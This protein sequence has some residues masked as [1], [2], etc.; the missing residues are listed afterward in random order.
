[1]IQARHLE[2]VQGASGSAT[3]WIGAAE[4]DATKPNVNNRAGAHRAR[5][6]RDIEIAII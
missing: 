4:D 2:E 1:M 3:A 6:F 5:L